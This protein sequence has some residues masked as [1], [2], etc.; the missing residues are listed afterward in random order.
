MKLENNEGE[1][2]WWRKIGNEKT[3]EKERK[4]K[5]TAK[6]KITGVKM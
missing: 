4:G 3:G 6:K 5:K 1:N 2:G